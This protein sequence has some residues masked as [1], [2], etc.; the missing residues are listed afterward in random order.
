[1]GIIQLYMDFST[2]HGPQAQL[3]RDYKCP[4]GKTYLS[5]AALFT[6][7][8]QKHDGK[9]LLLLF[10]PLEPLRN[11][12]QRASLEVGLPWLPRTRSLLLR[13]TAMRVGRPTIRSKA[14]VR[15]MPTKFIGTRINK[16][17]LISAR[18]CGLKK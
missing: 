7:I 11:R 17:S 10:R 5:Y 4:C 16:F 14:P 1:M 3:S 2:V 12:R 8:K 13:R 15:T 9:V 6:H 18:F